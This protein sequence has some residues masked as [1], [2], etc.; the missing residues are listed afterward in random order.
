MHGR[1][2]L[3]VGASSFSIMWRVLAVKPSRRMVA[4]ISIFLIVC[5]VF[6]TST[7]LSPRAAADTPPASPREEFKAS[8][9]GRPESSREE[10]KA[11]YRGHP[12]SETPDRAV[13][14]SN[15]HL[16][17]NS[18]YDP[19]S[20]DERRRKLLRPDSIRDGVTQSDPW[21]IWQRWVRQDRLY[22]EGAFWS[23]QMNQLLKSMAT[24]RITSFG[25]GDLHI[26]KQLKIITY[27][28]KQKALF[29][30]MW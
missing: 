27:L 23:D 4:A 16:E 22:P 26:G 14:P 25:G 8:Y 15:R 19:R 2:V 10:F 7:N 3:A 1:A 28:G 18:D 21:N 30:P 12:E 24:A 13:A 11:S 6:I 17:R 9:R 5:T 29:K 20:P